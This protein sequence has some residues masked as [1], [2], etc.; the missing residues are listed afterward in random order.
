MKYRCLIYLVSALF[1]PAASA[2]EGINTPKQEPRRIEISEI[3]PDLD[4]EQVLMR[5]EVATSYRISGIVPSGQVPSFGIGPVLPNGSPRFMVLVSGDLADLMTRFR[6]GP[7]EPVS[8]KRGLVMEAAG[9]IRVFP[10]RKDASHEGPS[11]QLNIRDWKG[12]RIIRL[13]KPHGA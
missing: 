7:H 6:Y 5:F 3:S 10:A 9:K 13:V 4:G 2:G 8:S 11:Y 12:F 1:V